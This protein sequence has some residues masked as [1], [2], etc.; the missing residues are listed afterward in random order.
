LFRRGFSVFLWFGK[1]LASGAVDVVFF[2]PPFP[3]SPL[4]EKA[5]LSGLFFEMLALV[6]LCSAFFCQQQVVGL[7][8]VVPSPP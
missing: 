3:F 1:G 6:S 8:L 4:V 5:L 7:L 2:A